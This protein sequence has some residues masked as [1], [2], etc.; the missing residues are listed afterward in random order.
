MTTHFLYLNMFLKRKLNNL[1]TLTW[2]T[3]SSVERQ[4]I[5]FSCQIFCQKKIY[6]FCLLN[7]FCDLCLNFSDAYTTVFSDLQTFFSHSLCVLSFSHSLCCLTS[8]SLLP[9]L[10]LPPLAVFMFRFISS[11]S[12]TGIN[13][14]H[15]LR[16][17]KQ[18]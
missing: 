18:E 4:Q 10:P 6:F 13:I 7:V 16:I 11:C 14:V 2:S 1:K 3:L 15:S 17:N 12:S 5:K 9:P 8:L